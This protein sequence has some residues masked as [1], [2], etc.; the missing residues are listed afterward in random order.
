MKH[1]KFNFETFN[2]ENEG[3]AEVKRLKLRKYT[4]SYSE[5]WKCY[6]LAYNA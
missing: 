1:K 4:L 5:F 6:I 2:T 3:L